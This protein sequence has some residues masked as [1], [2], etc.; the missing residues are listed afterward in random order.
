MTF[1][2]TDVQDMFRLLEQHPEWLAQLRALVFTQELLQLPKD[3][4]E[5]REIQR[6][7]EAHLKELAE[8]VKELCAAQ[9]R[10]EERMDQ[11]EENQRRLDRRMEELAATLQSLSLRVEELAAAQKRTEERVEELAAAQKRTEEQLQSLSLRVEELAAA[12]KRT[13]ER[14]EEL[15]AAQKRTEERLDRIEARLDR[16]EE[17]VDRIEI[18]LYKTRNELARLSDKLGVSLEDEASDVMATIMRQK[19][20]RVLHEGS[21]LRFNGDVD[22]V[23]PVEDAQGR[24]LW[25]LIEVK[26][27]LSARDVHRWA[28]RIRSERWQK[29][30]IKAGCHPP[31]LIYAYGIR[32][33]LSARETAQKYGIGLAKG[34]GEIFAPSEER[35]ASSSQEPEKKNE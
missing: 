25:V 29:A 9:K 20:Y 4:Q 24:K 15:A 34:D 18:E 10:A 27:R 31:Y 14:V 3:F 13:E 12:Q 22:V 30:L 7:T 32:V 8:L 33:D 28:Q 5:I 21:A 23:L 1:T 19:G 6:Q 11:M 26:A 16:V 35:F 17:R 2:I